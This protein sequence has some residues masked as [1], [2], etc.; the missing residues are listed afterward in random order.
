MLAAG[1]GIEPQYHP[2]KGCVLPL[3]EPAIFKILKQYYTFLLIYPLFFVY[4]GLQ[5]DT[6]YCSRFERFFIMKWHADLPVNSI[7]MTCIVI[8]ASICVI[9]QKISFFEKSLHI[10][11]SPVKKTSWHLNFCKTK[12]ADFERRLGW[13]WR[14][15]NRPKLFVFWIGFL[16]K[17][18][19]S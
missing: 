4:S 10:A 17:W 9:Q 8:M 14:I 3:D 15:N 6:S 1:Q 12:H 2:S 19:Q 13:L 18:V 5:N 16:I 11:K 7:G